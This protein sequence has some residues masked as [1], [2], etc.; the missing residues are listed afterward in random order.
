MN[1][2]PFPGYEEYQRQQYAEALPKLLPVAESGNAEAQCMVGTIY[3][4]GYGGLPDHQKAVIW[5]ERSS[6][7]GYGVATNNLAGIFFIE[8]K[9][10]ESKRLYRRSQEQGFVNGRAV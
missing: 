4:H 9:I 1:E 3:Q 5:Y 6:Q 7:Q 10:E 8:G 2:A